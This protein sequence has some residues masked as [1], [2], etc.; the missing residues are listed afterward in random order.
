MAII[1]FIPTVPI[2]LETLVLIL[3]AITVV[4][5]VVISV[6]PEAWLNLTKGIYS[7]NNKISQI[8]LLAL[9]YIMLDILVA[10]GL[11]YVQILATA[12]FIVMFIGFGFASFNVDFMPMVT[13]IYRKGNI[14]RKAWLY[15]LIW[16]VLMF[17]A[18]NEIY[19]FF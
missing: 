5:L 1:P 11:S 2:S 17:L 14:L 9:S 8:T 4:K 19:A 16:I 3:I 13:K 10:S 18:L 7:N 15:T 6:K 12:F